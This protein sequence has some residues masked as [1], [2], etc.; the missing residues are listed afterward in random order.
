MRLRGQGKKEDI[1]KALE[2]VGLHHEFSKP[3]SDYSLGMKQRLG[4]AAALMHEPKL[5]ILDEQING[6]DPIGISEIRTLLTSLCR[7][8]GTTIFVSSHVLSEIEQIA[9]VIGV[10]HEGQLIEE[11]KMEDLQNRRHEYIEFEVSDM[12]KALEILEKS[13]GIT[14]FQVQGIA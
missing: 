11:I 1:M 2:M 14:D 4:I 5:L 10:M 8:K 6:L 9:D 13:Y 7:D 12:T 3:F